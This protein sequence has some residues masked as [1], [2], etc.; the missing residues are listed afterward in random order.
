MTLRRSLF[1]SLSQQFGM[2]GLQTVNMVVIARLLTPEEIGVFVIA[3]SLVTILQALREMG[4]THYLIREPVVQDSTIRATFGM[5]IAL[6]TFLALV[7]LLLRHPLES[8][9]G[10]PGLA[11]VL[12]PI[13][14]V[15]LIFPVEQPAMA[16][17]RR[18]MR[19][20]TLH[21]ASL[22]AKFVGVLTSI[23][24]ALLGFS[25]MALVWG[26]MAEAVLRM[27]L[28]SY[29]EHRHLRLGPSIRGWR[30]LL[31]F[32][33]WT[34]GASLA[35][36]AT[37]EGN[38]LLVGALVGVGP[39][40][41]F[42]RAA[43]I[44]GMVRTGLFMPIGRV[45]LSS[46]SEDLRSGNNIGPKVEKLTHVTTGIIWPAFA[47]LAV[48]ADE[49]ILLMLG[50]QW[51][52]AAVILPW[53][54]LA[55]AVPALLPQPDQILVPF[56][57]VRRLMALRLAQVTLGLSISYTTLQWGLEVFAMFRPLNG[58]LTIV[59][60]WI[61]ISPYLGVGFGKL[62]RGHLKSA[63]VAL[64]AACPVA[65]WKFAHIGAGSYLALLALLAVSVA[66]GLLVVM[67]LR[68]PLG[69][70]IYRTF[71]WFIAKLQRKFSKKDG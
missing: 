31:G 19:F 56:G 34:S 14:L 13:V 30:P 18:E 44:P 33:L 49:V 69:A 66:L 45:M 26:L 57:H 36:Q 60:I 67:L 32:G 1:W 20:E 37:T 27:V 41:I 29:A 52:Q 42:D 12:T 46:F 5:S 54:L 47:V 3:L 48:L 40:A 35:G 8:W 22:T 16:L 58:M 68:H 21:H 55:Q 70:E 24:L 65:A 50:P 62:L 39:A 51:T 10:A 9:I 7:L 43:R 64:A 23:G 15:I 63:L 38:K 2:M 11:H 71:S 4:L 61:A 17:I 25:T 28:L 53:L 6:C 59:L